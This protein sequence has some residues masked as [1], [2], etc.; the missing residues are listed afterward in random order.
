MILLSYF[1]CTFFCIND[2]L[3]FHFLF[4][5]SLFLRVSV[6]P[7]VLTRINANKEKIDIFG[8]SGFGVLKKF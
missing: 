1:M 2:F 8:V 5:V 4:F 7:V 6:I 3:P